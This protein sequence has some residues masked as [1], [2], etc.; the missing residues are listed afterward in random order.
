M[1]TYKNTNTYFIFVLKPVVD[2]LE[3][4]AAVVTKSY[5]NSFPTSLPQ[6]QSALVFHKIVTVIFGF[7]W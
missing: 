1:K 2:A 6:N 4:K 3:W 5:Q 7:S